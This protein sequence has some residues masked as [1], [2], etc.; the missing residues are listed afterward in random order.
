MVPS[1]LSTEPEIKTQSMHKMAEILEGTIYGKKG[2]NAVTET[3]FQIVYIFLVY[4]S[5][6]RNFAG[7]ST[8]TFYFV[9]LQ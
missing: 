1:T 3:L 4:V 8:R 2:S 9:A 5:R 7:Y 6:K